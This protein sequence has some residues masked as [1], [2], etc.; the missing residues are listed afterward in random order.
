MFFVLVCCHSFLFGCCRSLPIAHLI[1]LIPD[2]GHHD[3]VVDTRKSGKWGKAH[4]ALGG[5]G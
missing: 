2:G 3:G 5:K 4:K 1:H